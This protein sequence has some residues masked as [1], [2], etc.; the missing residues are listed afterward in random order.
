MEYANKYLDEDRI[1]PI[2]RHGKSVEEIEFHNN[3]ELSESIIESL[4]NFQ[5]KA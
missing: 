2:V 5:M 1:I 3:E 4:K